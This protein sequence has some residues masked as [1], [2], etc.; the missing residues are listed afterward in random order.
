MTT[1]AGAAVATGAG[2]TGVGGGGGGGAS[3]AIHALTHVARA[4]T[5]VNTAGAAGLQLSVALVAARLVMP[6]WTSDWS[7]HSPSTPLKPSVTRT[8]TCV[9][10]TR[11]RGSRPTRSPTR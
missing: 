6:I 4:S 10:W 11:W 5:R 3:A 8:T 7:A 1:Q 9:S 2:A